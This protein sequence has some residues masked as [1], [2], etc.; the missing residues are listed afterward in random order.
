MK[1]TEDELCFFKNDLGEIEY[2]ILCSDCESDC[3]QSYKA[4][5][6]FCPNFKKKESAVNPP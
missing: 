6:V 3:K 4:Q 1:T 5:I 2:N